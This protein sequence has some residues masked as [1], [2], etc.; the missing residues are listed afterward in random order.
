MKVSP[1]SK[2]SDEFAKTN[3]LHTHKLLHF[4]VRNLKEMSLYETKISE[5]DQGHSEKNLKNQP[6]GNPD[7]FIF[8]KAQRN[9]GVHGSTK[10]TP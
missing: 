8:L 9:K 5:K 3:I 10:T 4:K 1:V 7:S 2:I 6:A